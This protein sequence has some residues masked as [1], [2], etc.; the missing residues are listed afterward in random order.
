MAICNPSLPLD[1]S[2]IRDEFLHEAV[3][4]RLYPVPLLPRSHD[5]YSHEERGVRSGSGV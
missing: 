2:L 5:L 1:V 3:H 4:H